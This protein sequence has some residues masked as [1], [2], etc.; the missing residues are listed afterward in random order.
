MEQLLVLKD[1]AVIFAISLIV[2]LA[3]HRLKLPALPGFIV[4]GM[5]VGPNALGLVS[6][7]Q[8]V[9]SLAEFSRLLAR[10]QA[11]GRFGLLVRRGPT[12]LYLVVDLAGGGP[13]GAQPPR[14][15][16]LRT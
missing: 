7:V 6:D 14:E 12:D 10:Q 4:A 13:K 3:F 1:L 2:V 5:L 11:A 16:L 15:T 8:R 9:E